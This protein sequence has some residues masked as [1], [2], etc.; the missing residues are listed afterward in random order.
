MAPS[1]GHSWSLL[2]QNLEGPSLTF[3][4]NSSNFAVLACDCEHLGEDPWEPIL[5]GESHYLIGS[6]WYIGGGGLYEDN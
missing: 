6:N 2:R 1:Q 3:S 4:S 5:V